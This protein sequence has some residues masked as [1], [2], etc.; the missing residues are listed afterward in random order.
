MKK[1]VQ[2][3]NYKLNFRIPQM[4]WNSIEN[5]HKSHSFQLQPDQINMAILFW[6]RVNI[7]ASVRI[8]S[9]NV[10]WTS[11]FLQ[12]TRNTR[13]CITGHPVYHPLWNPAQ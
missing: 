5:H 1:E 2:N 10:Y 4:K 11:H 6:Y 8:L 12:G 7:D 9:S 3:H 13:P